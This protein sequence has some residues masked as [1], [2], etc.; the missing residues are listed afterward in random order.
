MRFKLNY[1]HLNPV[2]VGIAEKESHHRDSSASNYVNKEGLLVIKIVDNL[3]VDFL[4]KVLLTKQN[5]Y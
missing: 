2:R 5:Q 1:I 3:V 4:K